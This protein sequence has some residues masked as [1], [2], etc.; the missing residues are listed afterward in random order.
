[1]SSRNL[2]PSPSNFDTPDVSELVALLDQLP[3]ELKRQAFSHS[4][5]VERRVDSY[6][7]LAFLG[8]AVLGLAVS[9]QLVRELGNAT[10][11]DLSEIRAQAVSGRACA[12]V[13]DAFG[14]AV[15]MASVAP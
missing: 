4:T 7:R 1:M 14:V 8:D 5:W 12:E 3:P 15:R 13:A 11:G 9:D 2:P 10:A 6:E